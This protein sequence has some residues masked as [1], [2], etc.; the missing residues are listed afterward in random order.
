MSETKE[1]WGYYAAA[2]VREAARGRWHDVLA[3]L[4][5]KTDLLN[6]RHGPCPGCGGR[7]RFRFDDK[8]GDG[9]WIC[10][11]GGG[12]MA[13]GDGLN[14]LEH[15]TGWEWKKC[16]DEVGQLLLPS[17]RRRHGKR[18]VM[19]TGVARMPKA[20]PMPKRPPYDPAA[21]L[22]YVQGT[23]EV[24]R[25]WIS[26]RSKIPVEKLTTSDFFEG[27]YGGDERI[28]IF[29]NE[30]SQGDFIYRVG[31]GGYRLA[32]ERN[33]QAVKSELPT[34]G[35]FGVWFLTNPVT[36]NWAVSDSKSIFEMVN[37]ERI[38]VREQEEWS[39]RTWHNVTAWRY[40]VLESDEAPEGLW[41][42]ALIKTAL[43]IAA[44][45][46][47]GS[48]SLHAL[49]KVD[50]KSKVEWDAIRDTAI[51][52]LMCPLGADGAAMTAVRLSRAPQCYREGKKD[53]EGFYKRFTE[54]AK[55]ELIYLNP[56][57]PM[58]PLLTL[59]RLPHG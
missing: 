35:K 7:D 26:E 41:L 1:H 33:V 40:M 53:K 59:R 37:G 12:P 34:T 49:I 28:L 6:P 13:S 25:K 18:V 36:G 9:T 52:P 21:L 29:Q 8:E 16:V 5:V 3:R 30:Y 42:R 31:Y 23:P 39:R 58:K 50:A 48:R 45:Y 51:A 4:G 38:K 20:E 46:S 57:P 11:G 19:E 15:C 27:L 22:A 54:P 55:Q 43:P 44:I 14:L 2:D 32:K 10:S 17:D 47:S 24:D 56:N